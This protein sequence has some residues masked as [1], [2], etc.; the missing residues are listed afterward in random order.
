MKMIV[1]IPNSLYANLNRIQNGS[2]A[3]KRLLEC[4]RCGSIV[5]TDVEGYWTYN[6]I[7][8]AF[9]CPICGYHDRR[10]NAHPYCPK[11]FSKLDVLVSD[12]KEEEE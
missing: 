8:K 6:P 4:L 1:D 11:C 10:M 3:A 12:M 2:A 9:M 5:S 7:L